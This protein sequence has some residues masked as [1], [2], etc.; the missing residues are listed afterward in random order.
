MSQT[1]IKEFIP[2]SWFHPKGIA[3]V[4]KRFWH[5]LP[6]VSGCLFATLTI[7]REAMRSQGYGPSESFDITRDRVRKMFYEL[8]RGVRWKGRL[9]RIDAEYCT[10]VE[11]HED[12]E[13]WPHYHVVWLTKRFVPA[14]LMAHLWGYGRTNVKR[15]RNEDFQYLLKYVC[16]SGKVPE[17][18]QDRTRMRILQPSRGFLTPDPDKRSQ[19]NATSE[20]RTR[21]TTT[22]R[23][24]LVKWQQLA[25]I[26]TELGAGAQKRVRELRL[27]DS[28]KSILDRLVLA[29]ALDGRYLGDGKVKIEKEEHIYPWI[30]KNHNPDPF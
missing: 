29:V 21:R 3:K 17:W 11:F 22:I 5:R 20:P 9:Y 30:L 12:E 1:Y 8:R 19:T 10:K 15:I 16:K 7:D 2:N 4:L 25:L 18:V 6:N 14:Q 28:F 26:V 24:R 23:E 13:G 27:F